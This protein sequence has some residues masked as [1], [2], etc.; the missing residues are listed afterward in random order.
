MAMPACASPDTDA[1]KRFVTAVRKGQDLMAGEFA[2]AVTADVAAKLAMVAKCS[3]QPPMKA[4]FG[5][6]VIWDCSRE[7]NGGAMGATFHVQNGKI[8]SVTLGAAQAR[9]VG[10]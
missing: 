3:A 6:V 10:M 5:I 2:G 9:P 4:P 8:N 1:V 7:K